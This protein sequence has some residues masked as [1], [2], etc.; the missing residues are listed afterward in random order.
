[1][2]QEYI[3]QKNYEGGQ[4]YF[5]ELHRL[6]PDEV[7]YIIALG[8]LEKIKKNYLESLELY[9]KAHKLE[10]SR[11][12]LLETAGRLALQIKDFD[13]AQAIFKQLKPILDE[14]ILWFAYYKKEPI[15]FLICIPE[16]NQI[17]KHVNGKLNLIGKIKTFYH[18][19]IKKSCKY[20]NYLIQFRKIFM[21]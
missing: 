1:M 16:M 19:K 11:L 15:G 6:K 8:E 10:P 3:L 5:E 14:K 20:T 9:L 17:F 7:R 2:G 13:R 21:K 4:K 12:E 18:L